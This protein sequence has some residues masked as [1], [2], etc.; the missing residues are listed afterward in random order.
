[1]TNHKRKTKLMSV[2]LYY[3]SLI[4]AASLFVFFTSACASS[5]AIGG[6]TFSGISSNEA[7]APEPGNFILV[8]EEAGALVAAVDPRDPRYSWD[9]RVDFSN[10]EAPVFAW[11]GASV[12]ARFEGPAITVRFTKALGQNWF[13]LIVDG[14]TFVFMCR[15]GGEHAYTLRK[16]LASG[17]HLVTLFKRSEAQSGHVAFV[18]FSVPDG[19]L[20]DPPEVPT[21]RLEFLGDSI[22]AGA[23]N[24]D[25][26]VD[27]WDDRST[28]NFYLSYAAI[29]ARTLN[30]SLVAVPNSGMGISIGWNK[31]V[32]AQLWDREDVNPASLVAPAASW[33]PDAFIINLGEN[34]DSYSNANGLDFPADFSDR[35]VAL[36]RAVRTRYPDTLI[37]CA[38]GGMG[39][40]RFSY[41]LGTAWE[42]AVKSLIASDPRIRDF[43]FE[44]FTVLHPRVKDHRLMAGELVA[45]LEKQL[46]W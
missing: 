40:G 22:T 23:C 41:N 1:M 26:F 42:N 44:T 38:L 5:G 46:G 27:Q 20:L 37:V 4:V 12:S 17:T 30:A 31:D 8:D 35:Y 45:F 3:T 24:E 43:R 33:A 13:N 18:G 14:K 25:T 39:G 10:P 19:K 6:N 32:A 15:A 21:R 2:I 29:T 36:V 11:S 34:D 9:G 16:D 7:A 28:H